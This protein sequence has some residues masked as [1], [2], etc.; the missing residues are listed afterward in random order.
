ME[1]WVSSHRH[2]I[3]ESQFQDH[4]LVSAKVRLPI[5]SHIRGMQQIEFFFHIYL[6]GSHTK[7]RGVWSVDMEL[8]EGSGTRQFERG[9]RQE[10]GKR[11]VGRVE[12]KEGRV[13]HPFFSKER[14]FSHSFAFFIKRMLRSL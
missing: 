2:H 9:K 8:E 4:Q 1:V 13:G 7:E 10:N 12:W 5:D 3:E 14:A 11:G 6:G